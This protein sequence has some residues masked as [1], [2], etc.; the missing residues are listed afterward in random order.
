LLFSAATWSFQVIEL[1]LPSGEEEEG[2]AGSWR[3]AILY[4]SLSARTLEVVCILR[5]R[6]ASSLLLS[7]SLEKERGSE[8]AFL[9][10]SL[11]RCQ[12]QVG[13]K[14]LLFISVRQRELVR[15]LALLVYLLIHNLLGLCTQYPTLPTK[16]CVICDVTRVSH[17]INRKRY[18]KEKKN[19]KELKAEETVHD[20][21]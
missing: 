16:S 17:T 9:E 20:T 7:S 2:A 15:V 4:K 13:I 10:F 19:G 6:F 14:P 5:S 8:D 1:F 21:H 11:S 12:L 3:G 18:L